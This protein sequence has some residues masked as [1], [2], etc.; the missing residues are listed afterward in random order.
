M[1][2]LK[3]EQELLPARPA[4]GRLREPGNVSSVNMCQSPARWDHA[5]KEEY[6]AMRMQEI[7]IHDYA[8]QL[9]D[10]HGDRAIVE[11]AQKASA[12]EQQGQSEQAQ[13]WRQIEAALKSMRGPHVS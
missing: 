7:D 13:T 12:L 9:L 10:A 6:D 1:I 5:E 4:K 2:C 8:R 3:M 11:A